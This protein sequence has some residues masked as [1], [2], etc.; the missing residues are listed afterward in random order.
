M[1]DIKKIKKEDIELLEEF[2]RVKYKDFIWTTIT[3]D[4][5]IGDVI[6]IEADAFSVTFEFDKEGKL[7]VISI[8]YNYEYCGLQYGLMKK[9]SLMDVY[10][11]QWKMLGEIEDFVKMELYFQSCEDGILES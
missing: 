4:D 6:S 9:R 7:K 11:F 3:M 10:S 1:K 2:M 8:N 5:E